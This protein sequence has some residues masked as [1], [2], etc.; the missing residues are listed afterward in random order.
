MEDGFFI[1]PSVTPRWFGAKSNGVMLQDLRDVPCLVLLGDVGMGKST[2]LQQQ[3]EELA[4]AVDGQKH[5]VV[6]IDLKRLSESQ[7]HRRI[8]QNRAV[9]AWLRGDHELTL[10][11]DSL[12]ECWRR[13]EAL[14]LLLVDEFE[15]HTKDDVKISPFFLRIACRSA[16]WRGD[17]GKL[18][19]QL[20]SI[21]HDSRPAVQIFTLA[22]LTKNNIREAAAYAGKDGEHL[23]ESIVS[24][25]AQ[26]LASHPITFQ[27]LFET[28]STSG[29]FPA[30]RAELYEQGCLRLCTDT[31]APAG[32]TP[33]RRT[34]P[35]QRFAVACRLAALSVFTNRYLVN[36][37]LERPLSREDVLEASDIIGHFREQA[38]GEQVTVDRDAVAE[39]LQTALFA[40]RT[41]GCQAWRHQSHAEFLAAHY[42]SLRQLPFAQI[43]SL[44]ADSTDN[45]Q[46]IIPQME[47]A[48][49]W[50]AEMNDVVFTGLV[51]NNADI[52]LRCDP[53]YWDDNIRNLLVVSYLELVRHNETPELDWQLKDR[54]ARL[55]HPGLASQL[56]PI[57]IDRCE[58]TLVRE[59]A[60]D[61]AGY[62]KC[63]ALAPEL[64][65]VFL[66]PSDV[67]LVRKH[68]GIALGHLANDDVRKLLQQ[69]A[70]D[71]WDGD[72]DDD[73]R[74]YFLSIL[75]PNNL[76]MPELLR[77]VTPPSRRNYLGPYRLFLERELPTALPESEIP[78]MLDWL[79]ENQVSFDILGNFGR[80][81]S[82]LLAR[83]LPLM[84]Q[85][86]VRG[87][88][89]RLIDVKDYQLR[90]L[91]HGNSER[92]KYPEDV[93]LKF[94][95]AIIASELD[96]SILMNY[97]DLRTAGLLSQADILI[98]LEEY[99]TCLDDR[100]RDRW[101]ALSFSVFS[102][103]NQNALEMV[104]ELAR[105]DRELAFELERHTTCIILPEK[106]NWLKQA[107]E[108]ET[109][110]ST[111]T[112]RLSLFDA[113]TSAMNEFE[114]GRT[115]AFW[116]V[117][118]LLDRDTDDPWHISYSLQF[119][120]GKAWKC[121]N[122][123]LRR[124]IILSAPVYLET[125][126]VDETQVW[127]DQRSYRAHDLLNPL[128]AL[129]FDVDKG[130][131][132]AITSQQ[133]AK[134]IPVFFAYSGLRNG[135]H[136]DAY[137]A[138]ISMAYA[139]AE[140]AFLQALRRYLF[141][142]INNDSRRRLI[143]DLTPI[144]C[145]EVKGLF[146]DIWEKQILTPSAAQ[147]I[148]Q[149]FLSLEPNEGET[150][151]GS[152][153]FDV[154]ASQSCKIHIPSGAAVLMRN[155]PETWCVRLLKRLAAEPALAKAVIPRL[156][157][158]HMSPT[159]WLSKI[160]PRSLVQ[161]WELLSD[162]YPGD[163]YAK[164]DGG[165][166]VT[167][168]HDIYH[169]RNA[170]FHN[171]AQCGTQEACNVMVE[172]MQRKPND[173]WLGDVLAQMKRAVKRKE[174]ARPAT[175]ALMQS[176]GFSEKRLI[177]TVGELQNL[178][179]DSFRRFENALHGAPPS[180]ELWNEVSVSRRKTFDPKDENN[181]SNCLK[182]FLEDDLKERG[183]IADREVQIKPRLG[184]DPAQ[185]IDILITAL[186]I[187][188]DGKP[189][190][191]ITLVIEVKC[192]WNDG[193]LLDMERQLYKRYL[194]N[195]ELHFGIYVVA[196]FTCDAWNR[197]GDARKIQGESRSPIDT[198]R[199]TLL[200]Q[201]DRLSS[202]QKLI[203]SVV[204]DARLTVP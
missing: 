54:F 107:Y 72:V 114:G 143:W 175:I 118:D 63:N 8:F 144:W 130:T 132:V 37:D 135:S 105:L 93:R 41:E 64:I 29:S 180:M 82:K 23:L 34:T 89:L 127:D 158:G 42:L 149:F 59:A 22:P 39:T 13:I 51:A 12:D 129:L 19:E 137:R 134:W 115:A 116:R 40:E 151:L 15:R 33:L 120:Q 112:K 85:V 152:L 7:I 88:V 87:A 186:P 177:R 58:P 122:D 104:S 94:W 52:F 77:F 178:I 125:Q 66:D 164:D 102:F 31:Q 128:L 49:C 48:A 25:D 156:L 173:V 195:S 110:K 111:P 46:R 83:A 140:K 163:P 174:W 176:F 2:T 75:W 35:Q 62:C 9:E 17:A 50:M 167:V 194:E 148:F 95:K 78:R 92:E 106:E 150:L 45:M 86:S 57:I 153:V 124:R 32:T 91:F 187:G 90:F 146:V 200:A 70:P 11:L 169:L 141:T 196:Y 139:K 61:I 121:L 44:L 109:F 133:W 183:I 43:K 101:R 26:T 97:G 53:M 36:G 28:Y 21:R 131:M 181:L 166:N 10:F 179:L 76:S 24:K 5:A 190:S 4:C 18:L 193:V 136:A 172:L 138:V 69:Q 204:I 81:P 192:A 56:R 74:G 98:F 30:S 157:L 47:E 80:L 162:L 202:S 3:A 126:A 103:E 16:E 154:D 145:S 6:Y 100:L 117:C 161:F 14:E 20:F 147:D 188:E 198:L 96:I 60:V 99:R 184:D 168:Y 79:R 160:P 199:S 189:A 165:G 84:D 27:M 38:A 155:F 182:R 55:A 113:I 119:S 159:G 108:R 73:L 65:K 1:E 68:A 123:D 203:R 71:C 170:V 191:P 67:F 197:M 171:F 185:L 142:D 201:A